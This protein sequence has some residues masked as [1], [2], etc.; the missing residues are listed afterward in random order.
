M[1]GYFLVIDWHESGFLLDSNH[2]HLGAE[3]LAVSPLAE[4]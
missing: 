4:S 1:N 2:L 3:H